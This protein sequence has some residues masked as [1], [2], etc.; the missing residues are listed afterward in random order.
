MT[1][2]AL[3]KVVKQ[4]VLEVVREERRLLTDVFMEAMEEVALL[5]AVREGENSKPVTRDQVFRA[6]GQR[7]AVGTARRR[8]RPR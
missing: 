8:K 2:A 1:Q 5:A 4:A 6:L 3:K 7:K